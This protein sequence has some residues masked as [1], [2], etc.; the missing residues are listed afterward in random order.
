MRRLGL[1]VFFLVLSAA[2]PQTAS[3]QIIITPPMVRVRPWWRARVYLAAPPGPVP[4]YYAPPVY[5]PPPPPVVYQPPQAVYA[6][7]VYQPPPPVY[8]PPPPVYQPAPVV[9]QPAPPVVRPQWQARFGLGGRFAGLLNTDSIGQSSQLGFGG[10]FLFRAS[11]HLVL[12]TAAEY[13]R[14]IQGGDGGLTRYDVPVTFGL[15]VH[16]GGPEW[17]VSP[18]FVFAGGIDYANLDFLHGQDVA[19]YAEGQIGGGLELRLGKHFALNG[20]IRGDGRE[21]MNKPAEAVAATTSVN[22]KPFHPLDNQYGVQFRL[23]AA[24]YF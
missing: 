2:L 10:E 11:R 8:Q 12:E 19:W 9:Y 14:T 17:P 20:D 23:G 4:Y 22:G 21:R 18:Y 3:A 16:I 1:S 7:P 6:P 24:I 5:Q 15:R 13:Q